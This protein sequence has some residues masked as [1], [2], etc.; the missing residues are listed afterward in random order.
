MPHASPLSHVRRS[1]NPNETKIGWQDACH[2]ER[3]RGIWGNGR[4][5]DPATGSCG[6][7][8]AP[9]ARPDS[10]LTLGMTGSRFD[11][12]LIGVNTPFPL[13]HL[14]HDGWRPGHCP[15]RVASGAQSPPPAA[16]TLTPRSHGTLRIA[17]ASMRGQ[18][19]Q[20]SRRDQACS[21]SFVAAEPQCDVNVP[22]RRAGG[23]R[24][25]C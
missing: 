12:C 13:C 8:R 20:P 22:G 3:Q 7:D 5:T 1:I 11:F 4:R 14:L 25:M 18:D 9:P 19:F 16:R 23:D 17:N 21:R 6:T 24:P 10:S 15:A 2:S